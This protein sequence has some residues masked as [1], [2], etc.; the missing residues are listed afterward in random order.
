MELENDL[1]YYVGYLHIDNGL[2][3]TLKNIKY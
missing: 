3:M 1:H 2:F